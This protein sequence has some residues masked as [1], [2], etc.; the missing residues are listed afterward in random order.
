MKKFFIS[1]V[2]IIS[3]LF[4]VFADNKQAH[5]ELRKEFEKCIY[6]DEIK[7]SLKSPVIFDGR[8]QYD[9]ETMEELGFEY[10]QIGVAGKE[11]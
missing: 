10:Y 11:A 8:N 2:L 6:F 4:N 7:N 1:F 9:A 5:K 3:L